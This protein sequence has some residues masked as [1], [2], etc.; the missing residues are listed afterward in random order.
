M[1]YPVTLE[2][3]DN[4]TFL[5]QIPDVPG[6]ISFGENETD[7]LENVADAL[8]TLLSGYISDRKDIPRP[9]SAE[10]RATVSLSLLGSLK[11]AVYEAM[12]ARGW[13]KADLARALELNPRQVDRLLDLRHAS[14]VAQLDRALAVCGKRAEVSTRERAAA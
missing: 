7:A 5:A 3:D 11:I 13:R 14:T 8:A 9:S 1:E 2:P 12:R 10:G 6:A 4:G